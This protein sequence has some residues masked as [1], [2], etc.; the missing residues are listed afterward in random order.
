VCYPVRMDTDRT[1][2][3][4]AKEQI[5]AQVKVIKPQPGDIVVAK[6]GLADMGDGMPP[7]IPTVDELIATRDELELVM[8]EGVKTLVYHMGLEFEVLRDLSN[9]DRVLVTQG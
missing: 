1:V 2:G 6:L 9:A 7:W 4:I 3:E 8:P 5:L